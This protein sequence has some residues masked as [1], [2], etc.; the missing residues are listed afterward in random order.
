MVQP[1]RIEIT[2]Q[3]RLWTG[4]REAWLDREL[5]GFLIWRD[6]KVRYKQTALGVIWA[7]L[8][9]LGLMVVFAIVFGRFAKVPS[10][11]IPY[12]LLALS[13]LVIWQYFS[14]AVQQAS[15]SLLS[16]ERLITR[17]Y[18]PR[19]LLPAA[20]VTAGIADLGIGVVL[21]LVVMPIL[22]VIPGLTVFAAPAFIAMAVLAAF[23]VG[24]ILSA[25]SVRYRDAKYLLTFLMQFWMFA[26]PVVY[27]ASLVPSRWRLLYAVNPMVGVVEGFRWSLFGAPLQPPVL[28]VSL[29]SLAC[30]LV[31]GLVYFQRMEDS[32]AD[33][34]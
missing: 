19:A 21:L 10:P 33:V 31:L 5:L 25:L 9:P 34:I 16:N 29:A 11:D 23:G 14:N 7:L 30:L 2:A 26:T 4:L 12:P 20:S 6:I 17:V 18:F 24:L 13:G 15:N 22:G 28:A 27:S 32:F 1:A 3:S 8:Q